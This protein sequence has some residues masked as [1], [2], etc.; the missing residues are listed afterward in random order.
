MKS[1]GAGNGRDQHNNARRGGPKGLESRWFADAI[2]TLDHPRRRQIMCLLH[3]GDTPVSTVELA[4]TLKQPTGRI[5]HH[6]QVLRRKGL[7]A[8]VDANRAGETF[9][10]SRMREQPA[11]SVFLEKNEEAG[12][13]G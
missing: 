12:A 5:C 8:L 3:E 9:Y 1:A 13:A 7:A 4:K 6:M 2:R 10:L 11:V